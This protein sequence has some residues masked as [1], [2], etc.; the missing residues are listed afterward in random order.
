[1]RVEG[2]TEEAR[3]ERKVKASRMKAERLRKSLIEQI[4]LTR[5]CTQK[6]EEL[7]EQKHIATAKLAD[8]FDGLLQALAKKY[9]Q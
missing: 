6:M 5:E 7:I 4:E 3:C 9:R 8:A 1:M 2:A